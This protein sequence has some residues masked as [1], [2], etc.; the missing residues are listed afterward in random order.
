VLTKGYAYDLYQLA[1]R[2]TWNPQDLDFRQDAQ[3]WAALN[4]RE[5]DI[6]CR[7]LSMF[8]AGEEAVAS[9]LAPL[10]WAIGRVGGLR[11]EEMFL[12]TQLFDESRH[13]EFF[14]RWFEAVAG[15]V[16]HSRYWGPN[17]RRVFFEELPR[18]LEALLTDHSSTAM[19]RAFLVYHVTVEGMLAETGY[20]AAFVACQRRGVLPG[21]TQGLEF[22]KRDESRHIAYGLHALQR[23]LAAEPALMD[24]VAATTNELLSLALGII[25]EALEPYG[26]DVPFGIDLKEMTDYAIDQFNKRYSAIERAIA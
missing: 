19:A 8:V 21:L 17:Y 14:H 10:L 7:L 18:A 26:D 2:H 1:K 4:L 20:H 11:Y 3:D 9:D 24:F 23:M 16:E 13:V 12:T 25:P 22:V 6:L 15:E 5:Q